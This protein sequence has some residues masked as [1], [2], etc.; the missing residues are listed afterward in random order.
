MTAVTSINP[1]QPPPEPGRPETARAYQGAFGFWD[2]VDVVNPLQHIPVV[3]WA[4]RG[5][6]GDT[7]QPPAR[8]AGAG[9]YG[10]PIG[11][12]GAIADEALAEHSR[13][14]RP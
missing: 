2:L 13:T 9:L 10:G 8:I 3:N 14:T 7:I 4:Y 5:L 12:A 11:V 6:T 1:Y